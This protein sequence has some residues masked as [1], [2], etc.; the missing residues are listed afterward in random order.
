MKQAILTSAKIDTSDSVYLEMTFDNHDF[1]P[2]DCITWD[3][4]VGLDFVVKSILPNSTVIV[5]MIG[6]D[7]FKLDLKCL[8]P[9]TVF[10]VKS[11]TIGEIN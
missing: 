5:S 6:W 11:S 10:F 4:M 7:V 2:S 1:N 8:K 3:K 9:D